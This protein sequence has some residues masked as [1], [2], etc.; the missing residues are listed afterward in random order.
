MGR[1]QGTLGS[2]CIQ[3]SVGLLASVWNDHLRAEVGVIDA[4]KPAGQG[5]EKRVVL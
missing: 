5:S 3:P 1:N 2:K 4:G